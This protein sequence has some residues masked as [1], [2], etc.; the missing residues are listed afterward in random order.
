MKDNDWSAALD[1]HPIFSL[2]T[3]AYGVADHPETSLELSMNTLQNYRTVD[4]HEDGPTPSGRRQI[5]I[6]K[7]EDL[8]VAAGHELRITSLG[9]SKMGRSS[10]KSYKVVLANRLFPLIS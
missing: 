2:P 5:M 9:D 6:L 7:N 10:K 8:I 1:D 3:S 4:P